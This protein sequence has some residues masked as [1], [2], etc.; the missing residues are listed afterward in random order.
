MCGIA[1][2]HRR[3]KRPIPK[4]GRLADTLLMGIESRGRDATGCLAML[5]NGKVQVQR[6]LVPASRFRRKRIRN[7]VRTVLLH[8]RFATVGRRDDV[9]NAHPVINSGMA[10]TH[11]GTIW[12]HGDLFKAFGL[13]RHAQVDSEI[14]PALVAFAGWD[15]AA[16]AIDLFE[17]GAA[18]AIVSEEHPDE[19][20][21]ARTES[22]PLTYYATPDFVVWASTRQAIEKAWITT[23]GCRPCGGEWVDVPEWTMVRINGTIETTVIRRP[24]PKAKVRTRKIAAPPVPKKRRSTKKATRSTASEPQAWTLWPIERES[25]MDEEV[26]N[27]M[28]HYGLDY[29]EAF[30]SV[31]GCAPPDD[32]EIDALLADFWRDLK[33]SR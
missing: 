6:E 4:V 1:G 20:I 16:E 30:D 14:I 5:P 27:L 33:E 29:D 22:Y 28:R 10:A 17:G 11:N 19:V 23:F 25:W 21:L 15:N 2:V 7:E 8:T 24:K 3:T 32:D 9:R 26:Q 12:N 13:K 31:Y 18:F